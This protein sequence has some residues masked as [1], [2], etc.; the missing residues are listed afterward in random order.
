[1]VEMGHN[2]NVV[3]MDLV[4]IQNQI[5]EQFIKSIDEK[6]QEFFTPYFRNVGIKGEITAGKIK[7]RGIKMKVRQSF[8]KTEYQLTQ[9]GVNISPVLEITFK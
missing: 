9:R 6:L 7:W 8:G 3:N 4:D 1:M 5:I 2:F